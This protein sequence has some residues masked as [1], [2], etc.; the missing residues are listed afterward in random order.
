LPLPHASTYSV[1]VTG[2]DGANIVG[3]HSF[4]WWHQLKGGFVYN[5]T[6]WDGYPLSD[7]SAPGGIAGVEGIDGDNIIVRTAGGWYDLPSYM[8]DGTQWVELNMPGAW[9]NGL[10]YP[11]GIDGGKVVGTFS[12]G[13]FL[14]DGTTWTTLAF[15]GASSTAAKGVDGDV[16]VGDYQNSSGSR[17][18]FI[19]DGTTWMTL[20][21]PGAWTTSVGDIDGRRI[22]GWYTDSTGTHGFL[23]ETVPAPGAL[24]LGT[25]G[26]GLVNWL[27]RRRAI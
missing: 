13:S 16:I 3:G 22:V 18:G 17:S 8:Y 9:P 19:Y 23:Y 11:Q 6:T 5:G 2:I 26:M 12:A 14:Y 21:A 10:V 1:T 4:G 25:L 15:P 7:P 20:D 27:R 24:L